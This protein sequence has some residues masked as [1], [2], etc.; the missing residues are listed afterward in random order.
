MNINSIL[1][2]FALMASLTLEEAAPWLS[3]CNEASCEIDSRLKDDV[4]KDTQSDRICALAAALAFY[5][6][7]LYRA[8]GTGMQDFSTG[9]VK[10]SCDNDAIMKF[11]TEIWREAR[12]SACDIL[13]DE[14]FFFWQV[15]A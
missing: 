7:S 6:Y 11:A 10:I 15:E 1:E 8:S 9:D 14:N 13:K 5:R 12:L 4:N 2:R 3:V